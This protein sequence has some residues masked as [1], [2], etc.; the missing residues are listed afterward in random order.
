MSY[1]PPY[2]YIPPVTWHWLTP[3]YDFLCAITGLGKRFRKK[4]LH[5]IALRG[6]ETVIDVGCGTGVFLALAKKTYPRLPLIGIDPDKEA[7]AIA[8]RRLLKKNLDVELHEA[9][10]ESLPI[11]N[12]SADVCFSTLAFHHMPNEIKQKALQEIY[13]ILK[14]SGR[15]VIADFGAT[16][17]RWPRA[18]LRLFEKI[19]Y[20][21]GNFKGLIPHYLKQ[22]GFQEIIIAKKHFPA[23]HLVIAHKL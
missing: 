16:D 3:C 5:A 9:F 12:A 14:P 4:V 6:D 8:K 22:A 2:R 10:A 15:V 17:S 7:L 18:L 11:P 1:T 20:V 23:I 19:E 13:R 21:E